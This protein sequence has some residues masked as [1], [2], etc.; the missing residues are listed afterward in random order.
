MD[1]S[2]A[3]ARYYQHRLVHTLYM[4]LGPGTLPP[5]Q[6]PSP[7]I[8]QSRNK[9]A[10]ATHLK[11]NLTYQTSKASFRRTP[12][13]RS[14]LHISCTY[15][16]SRTKQENA[17]ICPRHT[18][19]NAPKSARLRNPTT[20]RAQRHPLFPP[21]RNQPVFPILQYATR[22]RCEKL[23][24]RGGRARRLAVLRYAGTSGGPPL[25]VSVVR[26]C[27][28]VGGVGALA[29]ACARAPNDKHPGD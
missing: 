5:G 17:R 16:T 4:D 6:S 1:V 26:S 25:G 8:S 23:A 15:I 29:C 21:V 9:T 2:Q 19:H 28:Y 22:R 24:V 12:N 10:T 27:L 20:N 13:P 14:A 3:A 11:Q 7:H 18:R